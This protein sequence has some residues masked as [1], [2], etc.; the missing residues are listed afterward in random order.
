MADNKPLKTMSYPIEDY[1]PPYSQSKHDLKTSYQWDGLLS[2]SDILAAPVKAFRHVSC[3]FVF[4]TEEL[5]L[6]FSI[7]ELILWKKIQVRN[8]FLLCSLSDLTIAL[9][10]LSFDRIFLCEIKFLKFIQNNLL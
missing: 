6:V 1:T 9:F 5:T 10:E 7:F 3:I 2:R 8:E 4:L